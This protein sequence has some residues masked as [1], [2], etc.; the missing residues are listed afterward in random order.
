M[1]SAE[2]SGTTSDLKSAIQNAVEQ[3]F[4]DDGLDA[5][6]LQQQSAGQAIYGSYHHH[7]HH[8]QA[9]G[10]GQGNQDNDAD[11]LLG[12]PPPPSGGDAATSGQT[13]GAATDAQQVSGQQLLD[14]LLQLAQS[15]NGS[16]ST[17]GQLLDV[18]S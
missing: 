7:H 10:V 17:P 8:G 14:L 5:Q 6:A 3:V 11:D 16:P 9:G 2:Q 13:S 4:Q 18:Q 12:P 1:Q 15:L